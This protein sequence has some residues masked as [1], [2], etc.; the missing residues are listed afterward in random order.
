MKASLIV[1]GL[2]SVSDMVG[3]MKEIDEVIEAHGG[4]P[5]AFPAGSSRNWAA[6]Q[7]QREASVNQLM[8]QECVAE[9]LSATS[10]RGCSDV[11]PSAGPVR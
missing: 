4:W 10:R 7:T 3:F 5:A 1:W 8:C 9:V 11:G 2:Q 6:R